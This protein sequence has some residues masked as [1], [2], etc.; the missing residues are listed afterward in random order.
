MAG[1]Y[2]GIEV[3]GLIEEQER[4]KRILADDP[5]FER[6]L[7]KVVDEALRAVRN[8]VVRDARQIMGSDPRH[9][10]RA[11]R[12]SV[13][14]R[15]LG[16][17]VNILK[18]RRA[19]RIGELPDSDTNQ[20][21]RRRGYKTGQMARYQGS[22]RGFVLRFLNA[23][24]K[25]R[26]SPTMDAHPMY[27]KSIDERPKHRQYNSRTLGNRGDIGANGQNFFEK[28][29]GHMMAELPTLEQMIDHLIVQEFNS[30]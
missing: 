1:A 29:K 30:K 18:K 5:I 27:R 22:D 8:E 2:N 26:V 6:K 17:Q 11:V 28:S 12:R 24:A 20:W 10:A 7:Q 21:W 13:Y 3:T 4:L 15:V 19:G 23:P 16:G 9:A 14:K 25:G